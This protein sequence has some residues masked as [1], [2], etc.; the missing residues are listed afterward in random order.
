[1]M[2]NFILTAVLTCMATVLY[3]TIKANV[4]MQKRLHSAEQD[5]HSLQNRMDILNAKYIDERYKAGWMRGFQTGRTK[6]NAA[7]EDDGK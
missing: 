7:M 2:P 4:K 3:F 5:L 6:P 1:M